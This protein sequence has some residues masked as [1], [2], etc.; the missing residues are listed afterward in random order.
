MVLIGVDLQNDKPVKWL[1]ENSWGDDKGS[2][3]LW[4]LYDSWFD[5]N[6]YG[7]IVKKDRVPDKVLKILKQPAIK[8]PVWDP[9][10]AF[11]Q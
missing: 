11:V 1:V 6:V 3:G 2:K 7:V 10:Y 5:K 9:A 8:R 4:T